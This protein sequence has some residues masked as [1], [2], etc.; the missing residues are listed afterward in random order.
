MSQ[1]YD[2]LKIAFAGESQTNIEYPA[3]AHRANAWCDAMVSDWLRE[4][5]LN[6]FQM[7]IASGLCIT[8][9]TPGL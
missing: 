7:L 1:V 6:G 4:M 9:L 3:Y 8:V 5:V 2:N